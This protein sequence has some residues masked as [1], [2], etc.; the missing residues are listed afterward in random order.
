MCALMACSSC[1]VSQIML[2]STAFVVSNHSVE[3]YR[4]TKLQHDSRINKDVLLI[5]RH[6]SQATA[7]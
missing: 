4:L 1:Q 6:I 7:P 3:T 2:M 5:T